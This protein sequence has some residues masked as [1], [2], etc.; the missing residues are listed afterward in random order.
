[1]NTSENH[2]AKH[3]VLQLGSLAFLYLSLSFLIVMVFGIINIIFPDAAAGYYELD[4][5]ESMVRTGIAMVIVFFPTYLILTRFVNHQRRASAEGT[6]LNLTKWL[7]YLSLLVGGCVLLGD[8]ATVIMTY[9]NGEVTPRFIYKAATVLVVVGAAFHYYMLDARGFWVRNE[10][11]SVRFG[12]GVIIVVLAALGQGFTHVKAPT[13]VREQRL[14]S[15]QVTDLQQIQWRIQDYYLTN[16][17]LPENLSA[18]GEPAVAKA[19]ENRA[20]Y[21][22][23]VTTEG[24]ELCATFAEQPS[25]ADA[26]MYSAPVD[27]TGGI[28]NPD[29]WQHGAGETCF[30]RIVILAQPIAPVTPTPAK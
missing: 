28:K 1:M 4:S 5:S 13:A 9:L 6:Y 2:T 11:K 17:K 18:L 27:K 25:V 23:N 8:L 19:P 15:T 21:R 20:A 24:F 29:N 12:I 16:E 7:I 30:K 22:Y 14:D 10:Q 26:Q 3:F